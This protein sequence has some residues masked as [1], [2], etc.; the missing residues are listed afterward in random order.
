MALRKGEPQLK[1]ITGLRPVIHAREGRMLGI[2]Q[3]PT[4]ARYYGIR[5]GM[6]DATIEPFEGMVG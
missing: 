5:L 3:P 2:R 1:F 6:S 4:M